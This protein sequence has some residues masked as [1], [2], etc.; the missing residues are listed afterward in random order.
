MDEL[1]R[2]ESLNLVAKL[3]TELEKHIGINDKLLGKLIMNA[4]YSSL[5]FYIYIFQFQ[6]K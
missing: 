1:E 3:C 4:P 2:L 5:P 6:F